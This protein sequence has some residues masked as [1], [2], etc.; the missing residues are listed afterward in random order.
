MNKVCI[1]TFHNVLNYGALL[2]AFALQY[3]IN[4]LGYDAEF[5]NYINKNMLA[6]YKVL[7]QNKSFYKNIR[8]IGK[9][10]IY[11]N[12]L[13]KKERN[14][15]KFIKKNFRLTRK[16]Y[17][18]DDLKQQPPQA[19]AYICG[20]DQIWNKNVT[21]ITDATYFL[22]FGD[23]SVKKISYAASTGSIENIENDV[24]F[25]KN[26]IYNLDFISV[27]ENDAAEMLKK[28]TKKDVKSTL[29]PTLL[30]TADEWSTY[31]NT[32]DNCFGD[33]ILNYVV[34]SDNEERKIV[35]YISKTEKLKVIDF[36]LKN[37]RKNSNYV[38][39]PE[40][41][42]LEFIKLIKN[43][44]YVVTTSFH[45]TVFSIIFKKKFIVVPHKKTGMRV[46]NLLFDLKLND[47]IVYNLESLSN[48][49]LNEI[50]YA[51]VEKILDKK[52]KESIEWLDYVLKKEKYDE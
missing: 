41:S 49:Y 39:I 33:Y 29:D 20:S 13:I 9:F 43:A 8:S 15:N 6:D 14:N 48:T 46:R 31:I 35:E 3:R 47:R 22:N 10:L 36:E 24:D 2:Q 30:L 25:F 40:A 37:N 7:S 42:P 11:S 45:A 44:K 27:R 16:Y 1:L 26:N 34:S 17:S 32:D 21:K 18:L 52:R 12:I 19:Y 23:K 4:S 38:H 28:L 5:I 51:E 50:K